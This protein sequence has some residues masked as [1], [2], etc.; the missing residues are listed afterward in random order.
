[1]SSPFLDIPTSEWIASNALAFAIRD[2]FPVSP[3]HALVV[4]RR[5]RE[6]YWDATAEERA[7]I[8]EL[9]EEVKRRLEKELSPRPAGFNV[10]F[11]AGEAAGQTVPHV[12]VHVIPRYRGD[13]DDPRGGVR[14]VIPER[15]NYLAETLREAT[16]F[17]TRPEARPVTAPPTHEAQLA[18][19]AKLQRL[20]AEGDFTAT[21]KFA[22][23]ISLADLAIEHGEDDGEPLR[24]ANSKI[25]NSFIEL[26]W[27]QTAPYST[28]REGTQAG[29]LAQNH[30]S[31][32]AIINAIAEFRQQ[33]PAATPQSARSADG[34]GALL[35]EVT[36]TVAAQPIN[37]LQNLGGQTDPF[38]YERAWGS[39]CDDSSRSSNSSRA[40]TGSRT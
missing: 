37:Y 26:Y 27:Q 3:G 30:G 2:K 6:T 38:L 1:V 13:V 25:A 18:F 7:A 21:Y 9:V 36:R 24:L 8:W 11:N 19:L 34:Y 10:G 14:W 20:F 16:A 15:A 28:G 31:Q 23:L 5:L 22:L 39:A 33:N 40:A 4:T 32:A 29:V 12:H 17:A 35:Q